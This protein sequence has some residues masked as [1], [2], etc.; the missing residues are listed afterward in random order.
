[1]DLMINGVYKHFKGKYYIVESIALDS[2]SLE[3]CVV[4]RGLYGTSPVWVRKKDDFLSKVDKEKYP[5]CKQ[6]YRFE[7]QNILE[8]K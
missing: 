7:L 8:E 6:E 3:E 2:E 1:M 4:Y 5:D